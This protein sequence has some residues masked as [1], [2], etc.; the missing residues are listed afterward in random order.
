MFTSM[1]PSYHNLMETKHNVEYEDHAMWRFLQ[2]SVMKKLILT[3][4]WKCIVYTPIILS[5]RGGAINVNGLSN[6]TT[7][8]TIFSTSNSPLA[9][10]Q[11][12]HNHYLDQDGFTIGSKT[13]EN[14]KLTNTPH[15][16]MIYFGPKEFTVGP[17]SQA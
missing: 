7:S 14:L 5:L 9:L 16:R 1:L 15:Q 11:Q 3:S 10:Q 6:L 2:V 13:K 4:F 12:Y 17:N 8:S